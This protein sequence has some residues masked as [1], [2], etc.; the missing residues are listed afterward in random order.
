W[1]STYNDETKRPGPKNL[2][3]LLVKSARMEGFVVSN[4]LD[5]FPEGVMALAEWLQAGK[6]QY[7][8]HVVDGLENTLDAFH[9]LFDGRNTGK[10]IIKVADE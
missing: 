6:L 8:E 3:Q 10:L 7:K 2:W 4:Y 1:I 5:R 9:M